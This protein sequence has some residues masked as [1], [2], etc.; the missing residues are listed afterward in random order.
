[1]SG[2]RLWAGFRRLQKSLELLEVEQALS[3]NSTKARNLVKRTTREASIYCELARKM[4]WS[5]GAFVGLFTY[6]T[7]VRPFLDI[8][9]GVYCVGLLD[10]TFVTVLILAIVFYVAGRIRFR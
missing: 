2:K 8:S 1:M 4:L 10:G 6:V 9:F 3:R 7:E 5:L